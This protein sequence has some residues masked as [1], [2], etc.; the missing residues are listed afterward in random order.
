MKTTYKNDPIFANA[1]SIFSI[2]GNK[3]EDKFS[4]D[5]VSKALNTDVSEEM[6]KGLSSADYHGFMQIGIENAD[7][8]INSNEDVDEKITALCD[9]AAKEKT[10]NTITVCEESLETYYDLY[11]DLAK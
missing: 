3:F 5:I 9:D 2:Y 11:T 7:V 1:K 6:L 10:V 4:S 8:V